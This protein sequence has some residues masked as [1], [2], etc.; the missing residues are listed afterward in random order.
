MVQD[1]FMCLLCHDAGNVDASMRLLRDAGNIVAG[2]IGRCT[3]DRNGFKWRSI[4]ELIVIHGVNLVP[5]NMIVGLEGL[6]TTGR[7]DQSCGKLLAA[8]HDVSVR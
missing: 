4:C 7:D 1:A 8:V 3:A 2:D 6:Q 5:G